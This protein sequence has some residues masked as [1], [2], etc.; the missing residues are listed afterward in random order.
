MKRMPA[1]CAALS[2]ALCFAPVA[3]A[4][5]TTIKMLLCGL[6]NGAQKWVL[7]SRAT[8]LVVQDGEG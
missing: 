4:K 2:L 7:T 6:Y 3:A 1:T 8:S 5:T